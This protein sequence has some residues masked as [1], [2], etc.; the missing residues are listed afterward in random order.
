MIQAARNL[1]MH[2]GDRAHRFRLLIRDR[3]AKL[4]AAFDAVFAAAGVRTIKIPPRAPTANAY[5]ERWVGTVRAECLD[6]MLI[7]N[8]QHLQLLLTRYV[9]H[10]NNGRPHRGLDLDVPVPAPI[11]AVPTT[12]PAKRVERV[13]ILGGLIHEY[14]QAA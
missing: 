12:L 3:D 6:W 14:H 11:V 8:R 2:L 4:T 9:E 1:V 10:Y 13:D 5:A 7:W